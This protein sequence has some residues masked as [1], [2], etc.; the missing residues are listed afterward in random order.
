MKR[1]EVQRLKLELKVN[2][3][4]REQFSYLEDWAL[5]EREHSASLDGAI[6]DLEASTL[7]LPITGGAKID[8]DTLKAAIGSAIDVMHTTVS[9]IYS[10]LPKV[11]DTNDLVS[12]LA[13]VAGHEK[14]MLNECDALLASTAA[15]QVR[16]YSLRTQLI[17]SEQ[18]LRKTRNPIL[19]TT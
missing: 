5:L 14:A 13:A 9:S 3:V 15:M 17:Q 11:E 7:R 10:V 6:K 12:E 1:I 2:L 4:L 19:W 18:D 16:E 8:I